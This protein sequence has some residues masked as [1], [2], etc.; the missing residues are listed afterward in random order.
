MLTSWKEIA[1]YCGKGVRTVQRWEKSFGLPVRRAVDGQQSAILAIPEEIDAWC[2]AQSV[3]PGS[4]LEHLRQEV[5]A[6]RADN[7][8][9]REVIQHLA[10]SRPSAEDSVLDKDPPHGLRLVLDPA[11][12]KSVNA[13]IR[14]SS[15]PPSETGAGEVA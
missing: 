1:Q 4:E 10:T 9:L 14:I 12:Q 13:T 6:L 3:S 11:R 5:V 7:A 8:S 15:A 2:R